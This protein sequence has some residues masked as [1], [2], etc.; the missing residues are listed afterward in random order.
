MHNPRL[1]Q[2]EIRETQFLES[3]DASSGY[4][5]RHRPGPYR[6]HSHQ[7]NRSPRNGEPRHVS[8]PDTG[9]VDVVDRSDSVGN[10]DRGADLFRE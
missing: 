8:G 3:N 7:F 9:A 5:A 6:I 1:I 2:T 4:P 10:T